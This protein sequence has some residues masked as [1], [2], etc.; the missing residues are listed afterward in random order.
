MNRHVLY[1]AAETRGDFSFLGMME[2][3]MSLTTGFIYVD[4][5]PNLVIKIKLPVNAYEVNFSCSFE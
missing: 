5:S 2:I 1:N 4:M 3:K